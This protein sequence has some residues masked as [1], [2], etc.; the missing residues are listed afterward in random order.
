MRAGSLSNSR[1]TDGTRRH[2][3]SGQEEDEG[4][5]SIRACASFVKTKTASCSSYAP[6]P[7]NAATHNHVISMRTALFRKPRALG[8]CV[9]NCLCERNRVHAERKDSEPS[10]RE[11]SYATQAPTQCAA[12]FSFVYTS[13][14]V[15]TRLHVDE[16]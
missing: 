11:R 2:A 16:L 3:T 5:G 1:R 10:E 4:N 13:T 7:S 14:H 15:N 9:H 12:R 6:H 8:S